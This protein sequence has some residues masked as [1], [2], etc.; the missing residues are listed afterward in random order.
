MGWEVGSAFDIIAGRRSGVYLVRLVQT[1]GS[2][3]D[4]CVDVDAERG[5][6]L[7]ATEVVPEIISAEILRLCRGP[8]RP[9][10][11]V[12]EVRELTRC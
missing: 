11:H 10:L 3:C 4:H 6:I 9:R 1:N 12:A 8:N 2:G 7:H 5:I